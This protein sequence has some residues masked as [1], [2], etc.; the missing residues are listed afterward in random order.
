MVYIHVVEYCSTIKRNEE[1]IYAIT[2]MN[3]ETVKYMKEATHKR[4]HIL[5]FHLYEIASKGKSIKTEDR[6]G[7]GG[8]WGNGYKVS[9]GVKEIF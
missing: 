8:L 6:S 9:L 1:L 5:G 2:W 7:L 3:L 4:P